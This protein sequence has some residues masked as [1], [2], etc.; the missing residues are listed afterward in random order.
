MQTHLQ[1]F[2]IFLLYDSPA[3]N[4]KNDILPL[5]TPLIAHFRSQFNHVFSMLIPMPRFKRINF[6]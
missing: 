1:K 6:C 4:E 2:V 5:T 3:C